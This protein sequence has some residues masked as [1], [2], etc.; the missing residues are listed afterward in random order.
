MNLGSCSTEQTSRGGSVDCA[1]EAGIDVPRASMQDSEEQNWP[2]GPS[3]AILP[4][5]AAD[6]T[7]TRGI[8]S[9]TRKP[10]SYPSLGQKHNAPQPGG[11]IRN[12]KRSIS[13]Q[14]TER[15]EIHRNGTIHSDI[16]KNQAVEGLTE[17]ARGPSTPLPATTSLPSYSPNGFKGNYETYGQG[18]IE[19][20]PSRSVYWSYAMYRGPGKEKV[21]V[22]YCKTKADTERIA[23]LFLGQE[24]IGFD[25][26]WKANAQAKEGAK[27]NVSLIQIACE[28]RVAL[29]H[30][31]RFREDDSC[32]PLIAPTFKAIME[33]SEITKVGVSIKGDSTRL[34]RF[35]GIN[36]RGL[37]ELSHLYKLVKY[38]IGNT[39]SIDK[40]LVS[41]ATQV[42]EHLGLPLWKGDARTSDWSLDLNFEQVQCK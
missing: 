11:S 4:L 42:E 23:Q 18:L 26:E 40:R 25:I 33:S 32:D 1:F 27:K 2:A 15:K 41:L 13:L 36:S 29:F 19:G 3:M 16:R 38:S 35:M 30:I 21:K 8:S 9:I 17:T 10:R 6:L 28:E 7:E 5:N 12:Q 22:H 37:F 34:R 39:G 20:A 24:V 31:A 14:C